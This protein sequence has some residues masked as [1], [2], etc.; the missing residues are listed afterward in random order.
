MILTEF[1]D[2][3]DDFNRPVQGYLHLTS[4]KNE[5]S[6]KNIMLLP[7]STTITSQEYLALERQAEERNEYING[8]LF[9]M[10]GA[11]RE[12]NQILTNLVR[13]LGNHL[14]DSSCQ[15]YSSDMKVK[16]VPANKYTYPDVLISCDPEEFEDEKEDVLLNPLVIIEILSPSTEAYDRGKKFFHYQLLNSLVEYLLITQDFCYIEKFVRQ[17]DNTWLYSKFHDPDD[18][19]NIGVIGCDLVV[20]EVYRKVKF[21]K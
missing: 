10:A 21:K 12:H 20:S 13:I 19:V 5:Y 6:I 17:N 2:D 1:D 4:T 14:L 7:T 8:E 15:V 9:A 11:S 16:I 3:V 18:R